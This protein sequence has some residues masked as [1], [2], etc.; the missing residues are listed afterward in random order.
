VVILHRRG[1]RRMLPWFGG[2]ALLSAL[3]AGYLIFV[4]GAFSLDN[5]ESNKFKSV[6]LEYMLSPARNLDNLYFTIDQSIGFALFVVALLAGFAAYRYSHRR[7]WPLI[8]AGWLGVLLPFIL[9][10]IMLTSSVDVLSQTDPKWFRIRYT[11]PIIA[12]LT[13][14]WAGA[15]AQG[16][17]TL[18]AA[19][20]STQGQRVLPALL[21]VVVAL[22]FSVPALQANIAAAQRF[23][24]MHG[25]EIIWTWSDLNLPPEG[26]ILTAPDSVLSDLWNRP[27][28][29]YNGRTSFDWVYDEDPAHA[30]PRDFR[31]QGVAYVAATSEDLNGIFK[32]PA[33]QDFFSQLL[34]L[35]IIPPGPEVNFT[36]YF[37][38]MLPPQQAADAVFGG[39]IALVGYDLS[40]THLKPGETLTVRPFWQAL[41]TPTDNYSLF[42]HLR[43]ADS[44]QPV[45]Q[46]DGA[47]TSD[48]RLTLT[49]DDPGETLI[50]TQ[51]VLT[52]PADL[53]PGD[54]TL[55]LG[56]YDFVSGARL[57][58]ADGT[59][60]F[61]VGTVT[62]TG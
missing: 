29:G 59:N 21:M 7:G 41:R 50:G 60:A 57:T 42:V 2:M 54:Y 46:Y 56:L 49:W 47:P 30:T 39:Q 23:A 40:A 15:L 44:P 17:V 1:W 25:K 37:Y 62:V 43:P 19:L 20:R 16:V 26:K 34:L 14:T 18:R 28:S 9:G 48:R 13:V 27:Y 11:L 61:E 10:C 5:R 51:A 4:Y 24:V 53:P 31:D 22:G 32:T 58:L 33:E 45:A 35:K 52:L 3:T 6:G 8:H 38:R 55:V 12:A 36:T